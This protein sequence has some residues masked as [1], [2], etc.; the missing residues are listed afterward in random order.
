MTHETCVIGCGAIQ[1]RS[2]LEGKKFGA[3]IAVRF[4]RR[5][6]DGDESTRR[7]IGNPHRQRIGLEDATKARF[8]CDQTLIGGFELADLA[9]QTGLCLLGT[10]GCHRKCLLR[11]FERI[12]ALTQSF[13]ELGHAHSGIG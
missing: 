6:V 7:L 5:V 11:A 13:I 9:A 10:L 8:T 4:E 1:E 3:R 12:R 2:C